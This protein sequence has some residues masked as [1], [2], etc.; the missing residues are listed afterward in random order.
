M[1][2]RLVQAAVEHTDEPEITVD[3]DDGMEFDLR[4]GNGW[5]LMA[6]LF[7]DGKIDVSVYDDSQGI[8]VKRVK[9]MPQASEA[10]LVS[11]FRM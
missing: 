11:L 4:L 8:P 5:L 9:R 3:G 10:E 6:N 1:A 7:P 2:V